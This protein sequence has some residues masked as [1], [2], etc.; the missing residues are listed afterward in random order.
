MLYDQCM[1]AWQQLGFFQP[2]ENIVLLNH[3]PESLGNYEYLI[4]PDSSLLSAI[5]FFFCGEQY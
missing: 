5:V 4:L 1:T 2:K 3:F